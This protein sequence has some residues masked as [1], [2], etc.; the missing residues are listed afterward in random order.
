MNTTSFS[1][2]QRFEVFIVEVFYLLGLVLFQDMLLYLML[3][4]G[5]VLMISLLV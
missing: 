1:I 4:I 5:S 2:L 3:L